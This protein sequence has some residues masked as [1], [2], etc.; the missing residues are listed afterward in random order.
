MPEQGKSTLTVNTPTHREITSR[1]KAEG[2]FVYNYVDEVWSTFKAGAG[3]GDTAK[4]N[5]NK[6]PLLG[7]ENYDYIYLTSDLER[8][9]A[10]RVK[11]VAASKRADA[12]DAVRA[13]LRL[14]DLL[15][16][17]VGGEHGFADA[18]KSRRQ[19]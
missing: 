5:S 16:K 15:L 3:L 7:K 2:K 9:L 12:I 14:C 1:A 6:T 11:A 13:A 4:S 18:R 17:P 10:I 19:K 8:D